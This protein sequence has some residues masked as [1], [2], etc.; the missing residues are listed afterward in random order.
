MPALLHVLGLSLLAGRLAHAWG[1]SQPAENF[2]YRVFGMAAT[3]AALVGAA[4][5]NLAAV[6][7]G[8]TG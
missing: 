8:S 2:R 5:L 1:I 6:L 7:I 4:L 3:F